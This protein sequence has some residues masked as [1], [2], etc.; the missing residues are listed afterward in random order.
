MRYSKTTI[1][2][3]VV[4]A[5]ILA[6]ARYVV[7]VH[8]STTQSKPV[9]ATQV[10]EERKKAGDVQSAEDAVD[11]YL[12][13]AA[14]IVVDSPS[15]STL[16]FPNYPPFNA[17]WM[18]LAKD[19]WEQ[20]RPAREL[21]RQARTI[22]QATWANGKDM[23]FLGKCRKLCYELGDAAAYAQFQGDDAAAIEYVRDVLHLAEILDQKPS[24][25]QVLVAA[26]CDALATCRLKE[27]SSGVA[28][29]ADAKDAQRLQ[30]G[31]ARK[32]IQQL[33][34][35]KAPKERINGLEGPDQ[36]YLF[37]SSFK[38]ESAYKKIWETLNRVNAERT[39]AAMSLACQIFR[40]EKGRWPQSL[41]EL[42]PAYVAKVPVDPWGKGKETFGYA[43]ITGGL[44]DG[45]D[46]PLV[47]CRCNSGDGIFYRLHRPEYDYYTDDGTKHVSSLQKHG[48]QFRDVARW[49]PATQ[50]TG[51]PTTQALVP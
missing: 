18:D 3:G 40:F 29:T 47:Y 41:D 15:A 12:R 19:A 2:A 7:V 45:S 35:Q 37:A 1:A 4:A 39:M 5:I 43:L 13:A 34:E 44:P 23:K 21:A 9:P 20:N 26:G 16:V 32:L 11:I 28:L 27:I 24:L 10:T 38:G 49:V 48:G 14:L 46:R 25:I 51:G 50:S 17:E 30:V 22:N 8:H 33:F 6:G 31:E 36:A 42:I